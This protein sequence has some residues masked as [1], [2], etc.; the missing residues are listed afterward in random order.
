MSQRD[1][2]AAIKASRQRRLQ[3]LRPNHPAVLPIDPEMSVSQDSDKKDIGTR[4]WSGV[5]VDPEPSD[6]RPTAPR[7]MLKTDP[8]ATTTPIDSASPAHSSLT[9]TIKRQAKLTVPEQTTEKRTTF[10]P[11]AMP[12]PDPPDIDDPHHNLDRPASLG[13]PANIQVP[14]TFN[15]YDDTTTDVSELS[16]TSELTGFTTLGATSQ[17]QRSAYCGGEQF[18]NLR[19]RLNEGGLSRVVEADSPISRFVEGGCSGNTRQ[20]VGDENRDSRIG[21][22][23]GWRDVVSR[24]QETVTSM[25]PKGSRSDIINSGGCGVTMTPRHTQ[26]HSA[27]IRY[28]DLYG[29]TDS[30][31]NEGFNE[32]ANRRYDPVAGSSRNSPTKPDAR[33]DSNARLDPGEGGNSAEKIVQGPPTPRNRDEVFALIKETLSA[34]GTVHIDTTSIADEDLSTVFPGLQES[35]PSPSSQG[36]PVNDSL[37]RSRDSTTFFSNLGP[38]SPSRSQNMGSNAS[39]QRQHRP[40]MAQFEQTRLTELPERVTGNAKEAG[41]ASIANETRDDKESNSQGDFFNLSSSFTYMKA[42]AEDLGSQLQNLQ[43][44]NIQGLNIISEKDMDGMLDVI[45]T[46][47]KKAK[48]SATPEKGEEIVRMLG[49]ELEKVGC[50]VDRSSKVNQDF[51]VPSQELMKKAREAYYANFQGTPPV[52]EPSVPLV[53]DPVPTS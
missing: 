17:F 46:E 28:E 25:T 41:N 7:R 44:Q 3:A 21:G 18:R 40:N 22:I 16:I 27:Q 1:P 37:A 38:G 50:S 35:L 34:D 39:A 10:L 36:L 14:T 12:R 30:S 45:K 43:I 53:G 13:S 29:S 32:F 20:F 31:A 24:V 9:D 51:I 26:K 19:K 15:A 23:S 42:V 33:E 4:K 5:Q 48:E 49:E 2:Y 11:I 52:A 8:V 47:L 6:L